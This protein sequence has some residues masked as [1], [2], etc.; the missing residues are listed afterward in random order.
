MN[1]FVRISN[2]LFIYVLMGVICAAYF[3]Q[4]YYNESPCPLCMIQRLAM[5]GVAL[6]LAINLKFGIRPAHYG[7][8]LLFVTFGRAVAL[9]QIA[10]HVCPGFPSFGIPVFGLS[11]Y[12]W[13]FIV[14]FCS[15]I[16]IGILLFLCPQE[17]SSSKLNRFEKGAVVFFLLVALAN[18]FTTFGQCSLGPCEDIPWPQP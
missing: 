16:A 1:Q 8:S 11:L 2:A 6:G 15:A 4:Y 5:L 18:F 13:A 3:E 14:F 10:L 17:S 7:L 12:S 9:R